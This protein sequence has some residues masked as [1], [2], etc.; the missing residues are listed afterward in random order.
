MR[1]ILSTATENK[2]LKKILSFFIKAID[3][4]MGKW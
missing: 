2:K 4:A 1:N 3:K